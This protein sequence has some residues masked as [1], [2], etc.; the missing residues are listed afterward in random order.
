MYRRWYFWLAV[1]V[2]LTAVVFILWP[3]PIRESEPGLPDA[4]PIERSPPSLPLA[5][6]EG[7]E[8][9]DTPEEP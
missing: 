4:G 6:A 3:A 2:L 1:I 7:D 9:S 5:P 8:E